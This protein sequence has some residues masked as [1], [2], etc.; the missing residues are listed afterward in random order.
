MLDNFGTDLTAAASASLLDPVVGRERETMRLCQI[1]LRRKKNNPVLIGEPGVGKSAIVEGLAQNIVAH[2]A[3]RILWD[4]RVIALDMGAVVAGT[5]YRGQFEERLHAILK[6]LRE[7]P[8]VIVFIDEVHTIVGAGSTPGSMDAANLLKPALARGEIQCIGATTLDEY[9]KTIEKDGALERRFQK[10][11]VSPSTPEETLDILRNLRGRYEE[12]HNVCYT[13]EAL[14]ACVKLT[15]RYVTDRSLPDKAIDAMD[16]AGAAQHLTNLPPSPA[17]EAIER[18]VK[19]L[20]ERKDMAINEQQFELAADLRDQ[21]KTALKA[22][23]RQR[24]LWEQQIKDNPQRVDVPEVEQVV[25][26]MTGVPVQTLSEDDNKRLRNMGER[27]KANVIG[28]DEAVEAIVRAIQR[29]RVG[30]K[31]PARPIGAFMLIGPTGVGKTF[32]AEMLAQEMFGTRDA[33]IRIDMSEYMEKH[34]VS[35]M[36]GSPPG[37]VGYDEGGQLTE[38]VRRNPYSIVLF[39]EIEKAHRD[40]FN[41][42]LQVMDE[43]RLTDGNGA[44]IDFRNTVI[45]MTSNSGTRQLREFGNGVG[46]ASRTEGN[47]QQARS[48]VEKSLRKEFAPEFL[49]RLTDIIYFRQLSQESIL[50]IVDTALQPKLTRNEALGYT[51]EVTPEARQLL[52]NEGYDAQYGARP[53][54]RAIQANVEDPLCQLLLEE[55]EAGATFKADALNDKVIVTKQ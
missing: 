42:L 15:E 18:E 37:Y 2:K 46:F 52:A 31:D 25:A 16:E 21:I 5:K 34:T 7:N 45:L 53:L 38:K 49:N 6:E 22:L 20:Y 1:L 3:P 55:T 12:H 10:L 36:I 23:D 41:L 32:L 24:S 39:D 17:L 47:G 11:V 27:L 13:D 43:G 4:R 54:K 9:R 8:Q 40:V 14:E 48:I 30:L 44:T 51:L 26:K 35:R 19:R 33:L 29:N 50:R 28:Q